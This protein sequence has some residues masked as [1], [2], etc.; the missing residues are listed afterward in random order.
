MQKFQLE[1]TK[2]ISEW[3]KQLDS[4]TDENGNKMTK[5]EIAAIKNKITNQTSRIESRMHLEHLRK[6]NKEIKTR[7]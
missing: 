7:F 6:E 1:S 3:Q 5:R 4:G 2:K